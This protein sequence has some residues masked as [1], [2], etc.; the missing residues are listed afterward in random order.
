MLGIQRQK[1]EKDKRGETENIAQFLTTNLIK[2]LPYFL[3]LL[4]WQN[5]RGPVNCLTGTKLFSLSKTE[6]EEP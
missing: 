6:A 1:G 5:Y 3:L 4:T 2:T